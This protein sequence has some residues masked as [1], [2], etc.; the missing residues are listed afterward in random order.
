MSFKHDLKTGLGYSSVVEH[1]PS[2]CEA[3]DS[4]SAPKM[5]RQKQKQTKKTPQIYAR[6]IPTYHSLQILSFII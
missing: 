4:I 5:K 6:N 1:L 3:L 2:I